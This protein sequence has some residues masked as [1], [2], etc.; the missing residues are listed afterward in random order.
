MKTIFTVFAGRKR[1]MEILLKYVDKMNVD[2]VHIWNFSRNKEDDEYIKTLPYKI[3][4]VQ[5]KTRW[6]E[7]YQYYT[8]NI[9]DE[10][11]I[12][13]CD[14][15]IVYIDIDMFD[16]YIKLIR[17]TPE[18]IIFSAMVINNS[19]CGIFNKD[20]FPSLSIHTLGNTTENA[21]GIHSIHSY[22]LDNKREFLEQAR[23]TNPCII[24]LDYPFKLNINFIGIRGS[25]AKMMFP[26]IGSSDEDYLGH[27]VTYEFRRNILIDSRFTVS[28]MAFT[29][30]R[31]GGYDE[32]NHLK[33]YKNMDN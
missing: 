21:Y 8:T 3:F 24:P 23:K 19:V 10:D 6:D 13:K 11:I 17:N 20:L 16:E 26:H 9:N 33:L 2:Q 12:I 14:D 5:D 7:Y 1:Y 18:C 25:D 31:E 32:T 22:F 28:H 15:D 30:Q 27:F 4:E 29:K